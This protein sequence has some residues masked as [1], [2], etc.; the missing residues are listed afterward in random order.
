ML[1]LVLL[2]LGLPAL[3]QDADQSGPGDDL[4]S[5]PAIGKPDEPGRRPLDE[6]PPLNLGGPDSKSDAA[7]RSS[8]GRWGAYAHAVQSALETAMNANARTRDKP[9]DVQCEMWI[10]PKGHV[11]RVQLAKPSGDADLDAALR[12]EILPKLA[13]PAPASD[14]PMPVKGHI[15]A[16]LQR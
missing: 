16:R 4:P 13:L 14:M 12:N 9:F 11:S 1:A 10:D 8:G 5:I 7:T 6:P 3:A 15:T 2:A